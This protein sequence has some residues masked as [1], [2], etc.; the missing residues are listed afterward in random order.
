M[1]NYLADN[2]VLIIR[3]A[4]KPAEG[5]GL[6]PEG[7][8]RAQQY[9]TYF[10]PFREDDLE[11]WVDGLYAGA[12]SRNSSRPRLTLEPLSRSAGLPINAAFGTKQ[13]SA[14]VETLKT[15][16]HGVCP[17][18][19][20]R[21]KELP[22]LLEALGA[23]PEQLLPGGLWPQG[24]FDSVVVL[25]FNSTGFLASQKLIRENLKVSAQD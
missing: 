23:S 22:T 5:T 21:H 10:G 13:S 16:P 25:R 15:L 14:L 2:T 20:W 8:Q 19:V 4:E 3:H 9:A 24:I 12:D 1:Q 6:S 7:E 17:L 11:L 18:I